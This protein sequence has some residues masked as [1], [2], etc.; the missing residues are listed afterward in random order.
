MMTLS[1]SLSNYKAKTGDMQIQIN[2]KIERYLEKKFRISHS[3][4]TKNVYHAALKK[5]TEFAR[6]RYNFSLDKMLNQI[7]ENNEDP[8]DILDEY[9]TFLS[10]YKIKTK[11]SGYSSEA[12]NQY[13]RITKDFFESPRVQDL[14]RGHEDEVSP[15]K[16]S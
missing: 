9:Y 8:L 11:R 5:F 4:N 6:V 16:K 15:P 2:D 14:Q 12:I 13:I 3:F 1:R 10:S 7:F